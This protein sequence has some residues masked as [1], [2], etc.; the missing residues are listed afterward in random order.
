MNNKNLKNPI[1]N[2]QTTFLTLKK[3]K[4]TKQQKKKKKTNKINQNDQ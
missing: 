4:K 2:K 1:D 3:E